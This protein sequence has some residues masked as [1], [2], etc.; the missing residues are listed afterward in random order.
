MGRI[1]NQ[2]QVSKDHYFFE[3]YSSERR[4]ISYYH[5]VKQVLNLVA[6]HNLKKILITGKGD[7]VV[8]KIL[9]AYSELLNLGLTIHTFDFA[10]YLRP[11]HLG[12]LIDIDQIVAEKYDIIVSCQILEHIPLKEADQVLTKMK[13]VSRF[14]IMS[15]PY[16]A[17]TVRGSFKMPVLPELVFCIKVPLIRSSG[18][19]VDERHYWELGATISVK[20]YKERLKSFGYSILD[21]YMMKKHGNIYF[22]IIQS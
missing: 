4:Y 6:Q 20:K 18:E 15:V 12:E 11:S 10:E 13:K 19:M 16:K 5:Q 17:I 22:F 9:E 7:G 14:V 2:L 21:S 1:E 3:T 8:P